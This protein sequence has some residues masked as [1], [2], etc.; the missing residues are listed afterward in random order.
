M[1]DDDLRALGATE[2]SRAPLVDAAVRAAF[3]TGAAVR[4]REQEPLGHTR[5]PRY[6]RG[7]RG[8]VVRVSLPFELPDLA[9]HAL[10]APAEPT[11]H[12]ELTARELWGPAASAGDA[13]VV[14]LWESYL[15][16][17]Q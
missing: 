17:A 12:V 14:D 2:L 15:E 4:V 8:V 5:A 1:R 10:P 9:A 11:Y 13:V 3:A 7:K 6:V 16:A